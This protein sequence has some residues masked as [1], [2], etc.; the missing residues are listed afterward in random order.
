MAVRALATAG[1]LV[2][3]CALL[4]GCGGS[5]RLSASAYRARL[6]ELGREATTAQTEVEKGLRA[7]TVAEL[8]RR[9]RT[10]ADAEQRLGDEVA[11]LKPPKNAEPAN[12]ELARGE[13]D[14]A[15]EIRAVEPRLA[16]LKTVNEAVRFL[17]KNVGSARGG[18]EVDHAL[19]Q[20]RKLG[21]AT[22]S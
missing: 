1:A 6:V 15:N 9:L 21:Y 18:R 11:K 10:F 20:L 17:N 7:K 13:R 14:L 16:K 8:R 5:G 19:R 12:A 3:P 4:A 22:G 2:L